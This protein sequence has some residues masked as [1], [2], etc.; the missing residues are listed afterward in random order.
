MLCQHAGLFVFIQEWERRSVSNK[1]TPVFFLIVKLCLELFKP[2]FEVDFAFSCVIIRTSK[3]EIINL[4]ACWFMFWH[5]IHFI[6][7]CL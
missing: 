6:R 2:V 3:R 1:Q 4:K 5:E 7:E